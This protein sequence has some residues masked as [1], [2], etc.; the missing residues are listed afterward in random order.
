MNYQQKD[1]QWKLIYQIGAVCAFLAFLVMAAE[2][3]IT[4]LPDGARE[5]LSIQDLFDLYTR[6]WFMGMRFM[7]LMN[8]FA[9]TLMI[10]TMVAILGVHRKKDAGLAILILVIFAASYAIFMADN[11]AFPMLTI[12]TKYQAATS[13]T[14]KQ[15]LLTAAESLWAKGASHTPGTFPGFFLSITV[16]FL[17]GWLLLRN[18]FFPKTTALIGIIAFAF[19]MTF[20]I[21]SSFVPSMF[22]VAIIFAG[23]GGILVYVW[24]ILVGL[25]LLRI[26]Q[27]TGNN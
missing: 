24:Y 26:S 5:I 20:E 7:G 16:Q 4:F 1:N 23:I 17:L 13:E 21:T 11:A 25:R 9:T 12:H 3:G 14:T 8:I 6:N 2:M 15:A 22:D 27:K 19:L 18:D 10:P